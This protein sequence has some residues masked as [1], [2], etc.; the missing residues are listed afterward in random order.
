MNDIHIILHCLPR[1]IDDLERIVNQLKV[2]SHYLEKKDSQGNKL[3]TLDA[4]VYINSWHYRHE[5]K[6]D[7][8]GNG[9]QSPL[10]KTPLLDDEGYRIAYG[11]QGYSN[12]L[13]HR[14]FLEIIDI[15]EEVRNFL[16]DEVLPLKRGV[17]KKV[18]ESTE[19]ELLI[20]I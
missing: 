5:W 1:E 9:V 20:A 18:E 13:T 3:G 10:S 8:Q 14:E 2:S 11:G 12:Y 15:S 17:V 4:L 16:I 19:E 7:A 6:Q